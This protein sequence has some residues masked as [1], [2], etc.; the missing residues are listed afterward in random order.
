[1]VRTPVVLTLL[2]AGLFV[3]NTAPLRAAS[4]ALPGG[5][6]RVTHATGLNQ[7]TAFAF[8]GKRIFVTEKNGDVRIIRADG[9]VRAKPFVSLHVSFNSERGVLGVALSPNF[10]QDRWVYVYYTTGEGAKNYSGE[11]KNRVSRFKYRKGVSVREKIILDNIPSDN[12]NHNGGDI[13][14]GSDGKLYIAIGESGCG[15]CPPKAQELD[16]LRGKLL[17][18]NPNGTIPSSNPFYN[19]PGA[20]QEIY[21]YGFRNPWRFTERPSNQ[22]LL[23]ADVGAGTWEEISTLVVGGN[24]GW[25]LFEGPCEGAH[26]DCT[27]GTTDFGSTVPP[28]HYYKHFGGGETGNVIAGGVFAEGS[29][30]P[31]LYGGAYFYADEGA[32]WVHGLTLD[33]GNNE[34]GH[35]DFDQLNCPVSFA[36]GPDHNVYV[37]DICD[38]VIYKYVYSAS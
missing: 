12:G 10:D 27:P 19:T 5:F 7:P 24:H 3:S 29:N 22:T 4:P 36:R 35:F 26:P 9:S 30:Y 20:R 15:D 13:H 17:R 14:F 38:G 18:I 1:M 6:M 32:G 21:A 11:P 23:V 25:N 31:D 8:L 33:G 34:T 2:L 16:N 28:L 37:A